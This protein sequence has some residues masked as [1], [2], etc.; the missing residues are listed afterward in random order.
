MRQRQR[1]NGLEEAE[2]LVRVGQASVAMRVSTTHSLGLGRGDLGRL[3]AA[4]LPPNGSNWST[5]FW[6]SLP[7]ADWVLKSGHEL[8]VDL[9][10]PREPAHTRWFHMFKRQVVEVHAWDPQE[11]E[12]QEQQQHCDGEKKN[13]PIRSDHLLN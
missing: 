7:R 4:G 8:A 3:V 5:T 12:M 6:H 13:R 1:T 9:G 10:A 11:P 2:E